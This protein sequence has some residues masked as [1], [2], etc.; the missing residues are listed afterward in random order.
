MTSFR[1]RIAIIAAA[2]AVA[3]GLVLSSVTPATAGTVNQTLV[4]G[5]IFNAGVVIHYRVTITAPDTAVRG[6]TA[7]IT[8]GIA[9]VTNNP[10]EIKAGTNH[11]LLDVTLGGPSPGVVTA[12]GL[13]NPY[14]APGT[15]FR[16]EGGTAQVT[17]TAAGDVTYRATRLNGGFYVCVPAGYPQ[18]VAAVTRVS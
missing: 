1:R 5:S 12:I 3:G 4:C 11:A 7:T 2:T 13:T 16:M 10:T 14:I 9:H 18:P 8:V 6:Q 17:F 15:P